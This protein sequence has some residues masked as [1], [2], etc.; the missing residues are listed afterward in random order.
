LMDIVEHVEEQRKTISRLEKKTKKLQKVSQESDSSGSSLSS[1]KSSKKKRSKKE[2][3]SVEELESKERKSEA[4]G[5]S[6]S[7]VEPSYED[8]IHWLFSK[9][10]IALKNHKYHLK[11]YKNCFIASDAVTLVVKKY[12][13]TPERACEI[14]VNL[15][16]N[17]V[18]EH[19]VDAKKPFKNGFLF[20]RPTEKV[21]S[22]KQNIDKPEVK[23]VPEGK[24]K[25][26][27]NWFERKR[28]S[29]AFTF[30]IWFRGDW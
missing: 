20:F 8:L 16:Q 24:G 28:T 13:L 18:I 30:A 15:Q 27:L 4:M 7:T 19:V 29:A 11:T 17:N 23:K 21:N 26:V 14:L 2:K 9:D 6:S 12:N 25:E 5:E 3:E 22:K 10:G 1:T